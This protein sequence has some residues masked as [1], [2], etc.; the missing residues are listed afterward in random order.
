VNLAGSLEAFALSDVLTLLA[1]TG[2]SGRLSLTRLAEG[3][4]CSGFVVLAGGRLVA[5]SGDIRRSARL[6]RLI[7]HGD[8]SFW[9]DAHEW[10]DEQGLVAA[11]VGAGWVTEQ[12]LAHIGVRVTTDALIELLAWPKGRFEFEVCE[13]AITDFITD[14]GVSEVLNE[15]HRRD[16]TRAGTDSLRPRA[17]SVLALPLT[18]VAAAQIERDDWPLLALLDGIRTAGEVA[19]LC[20]RET[21]S[22]LDRFASLVGAGLVRE[23]PAADG[24][25]KRLLARLRRVAEFEQRNNVLDRADVE[26]IA[27]PTPAALSLAPESDFA[28]GWQPSD[29]LADLALPVDREAVMRLIVGVQGL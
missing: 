3:E 25:T 23:Y 21:A 22:V 14:L 17:D 29:A 13:P 6:R 15:G 4:K 18:I 26:Q 19:E 24:P 27:G 8:D 11:L 16:T 28:A 9:A 2:K 12:E 1:S 20:G 5:A 7:G 10:P